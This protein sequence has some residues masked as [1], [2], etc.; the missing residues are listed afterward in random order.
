VTIGGRQENLTNVRLTAEVEHD[1]DS[2]R[3]P[4]DH[5]GRGVGIDA[6][7]RFGSST[8]EMLGWK[9]DVRTQHMSPHPPHLSKQTS[10]NM[11]LGCILSNN[12]AIELQVVPIAATLSVHSLCRRVILDLLSPTSMPSERDKSQEQPGRYFYDNL[13]SRGAQCGSSPIRMRRCVSRGNSVCRSKPSRSPA[14]L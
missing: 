1:G 8:T 6:N 13:Q 2:Y 7:L 12:R 14:T 4:C 10:T 3:G 5:L 11:Q 9:L